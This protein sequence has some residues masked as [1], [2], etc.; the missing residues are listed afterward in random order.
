MG[1]AHAMGVLICV[2]LAPHYTNIFN[3]SYSR[4]II[5]NYNAIYLHSR[6]ST[7]NN[8]CS[9]IDFS[10]AGELTLESTVHAKL[11]KP[12]FDY[13]LPSVITQLSF[14]PYLLS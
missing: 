13:T 4:F 10:I 1:V 7:V 2:A 12:S 6:S 5:S 11:H 14:K 8:I 3:L 9:F